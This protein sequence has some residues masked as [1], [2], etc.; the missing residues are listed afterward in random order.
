MRD[1]S[2][3]RRDRLAATLR[4]A[5]AALTLLL[6]LI[7]FLG[8]AGWWFDWA[9]VRQGPFG[10]ASIKP[11]TSFTFTLIALALWSQDRP[12]SLSRA[13]GIASLVLTLAIA[14][15]TLTEHLTGWRAGIDGVLLPGAMQR[16]SDV[17]RMS[18]LSAIGLLFL[19]GGQLLDA[20]RRARGLAPAQIGA[21]LALVVGLVGVLGFLYRHGGFASPAATLLLIPLPT[22]FGIAAAALAIIVRDTDGRIGTVFAGVG[23]AGR[24]AR[25]L[26]LIV[27]PAVILAVAV[28]RTWELRGLLGS[29]EAALLRSIVIFLPLIIV[30]WRAFVALRLDEAALEASNQQLRATN[31]TLERKVDERTRNLVTA[32]AEAQRTRAQ[33]QAVLLGADDQIAA[34][35]TSLRYLFFNRNFARFLER[36]VGEPPLLGTS[37]REQFG[38]TPSARDAAVALWERG[39]G[40]ENFH[41]QFDVR[42]LDDTQVVVERAV[43]PVRDE[44]G[45]I[46]GAVSVLRDVTASRRAQEQ[47]AA[48][49]RDLETLLH[50]ASHDLKEPLRS[51]ESFAHLLE[52]GYR[53][54]L[55]GRGHDF[56]RRIARTAAR[57]TQ[58]LS[59]VTTLAAARRAPIPA[60]PVEGGALVREVLASLEAPLRETNA[61]VDVA[62][63]FPDV[64]WVERTWAR[65]ALYN[66]VVNA[67]KYSAPG[68]APEL[69]IAAA[70]RDGETGFVVRDRGRGVAPADRERI[71]ELFQRGV[72]RDVPGTGAGLAIVRQVAERYGGHAWVEARDGG[73]SNF[74]FTLG[75]LRPRADE[76]P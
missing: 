8:L 47:I 68:H 41:Q 37:V 66:L 30:T 21:V 46:I 40:G 32:T 45:D 44:R 22:A 16:D 74:F 12:E 39:L 17:H 75:R 42:L 33:L 15:L 26:F 4:R 14:A 10:G 25:L 70:G 58:L 48:R 13:I 28:V 51:V 60:E 49:N 43:S 18:P 9:A 35:D 56:V 62:P 72:G 73:G 23:T 27:I 6:L 36:A 24:Q 55:D 63:T 31:L 65:Q 29:G 61:R 5:H 34:V 64:L 38:A 7:G 57:M 59:D 76:A 53:D 20:Q 52:T 71:F 1:D 2:G 54:H 19:A 67:L 11:N 50:V 69:E 3:R